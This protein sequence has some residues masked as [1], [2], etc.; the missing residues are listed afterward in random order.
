MQ[1]N[2][3]YLSSAYQC[4]PRTAKYITHI[5]ANSTKIYHFKGH[6]YHLWAGCTA[7][8]FSSSLLWYPSTV[9]Q[10]NSSIDASQNTSAEDTD[11]SWINWSM[12]HESAFINFFFK[13]NSFHIFFNS[14]FKLSSNV[15]K[16][17]LPTL[18][19]I[20]DSITYRG[21]HTIVKKKKKT[22]RQLITKSVPAFSLLGAGGFPLHQWHSLLV[23]PFR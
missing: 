2:S 13:P 6:C 18:W 12:I 7:D 21:L 9:T 3:M 16:S 19:N 14:S 11:I 1:L 22:L 23:F 15:S 20:Q 10:S 17:S 4:H 5:A 8:F